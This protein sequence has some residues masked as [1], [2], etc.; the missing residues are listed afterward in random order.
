MTGTCDLVEVWRGDMVE[1]RHAGHAVVMDA[2]GAVV[3]E[4]GAP[5]LP[6]YPRSSCKMLQALPLVES[7]AAAGLDDARLALACASHQGARLHVAAVSAWLADI[8]LREADLRCGAQEPSD[9]AER[10]SLILG[11]AEPCQ[12]HNNC[13]GK[14]T[15][16]LTLAR[17]LRA[18]PEYHEID[19]PVQRAARAAFDEVT[20]LSLPGHA[21]DGCSA[22][23]FPTTTRA[24]ARAMATF[25]GAE[26]RA[27]VRA[28]A[29]VRLAAAMR[30]HPDLVAGEGRAC[31]EFMRATSGRAAV[32]TGAEGVF[33]AILPERGLGIAL[34]I[35]DGATR[36]AEAA[37]AALLIRA[38]V[39]DPAHPAAL[40]RLGGPM[41]N[42]RGLEVGA[43]RLAPGFA[44]RS[45]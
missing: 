8:G 25:A 11:A 42:W 45:L 44:D 18:G 31:T 6:I 5:D 7:G 3:A 37:M 36:A 19:H 22:P 29:M 16:F 14:H 39:L 38:G 28:A 33:V 43:V 35:A 32:K 12:M 17:H 40:R 10:D 24:L 21:I 41:R 15:G 1:S 34:K 23:N 20:D 2:S 26:G 30:A 4:W 9:R 13:S 27:G